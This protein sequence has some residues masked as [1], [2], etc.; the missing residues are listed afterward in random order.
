MEEGHIGWADII[1]VM[2][3][4][5]L[6]RIRDKFGV[7][8]NDKKIVNLDIADDYQ[9]MDEELIEILQNRVSEII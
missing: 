4:K 1:F 6:R 8:L 5:H 2:E 3:K 7:L 9:F